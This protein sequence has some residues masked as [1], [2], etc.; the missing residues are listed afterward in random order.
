MRRH[1]NNLN[2]GVILFLG[3]SEI[4]TL[5][6]NHQI[7]LANRTLLLKE[8]VLLTYQNP[9]SSIK[10]TKLSAFS[11]SKNPPISLDKLINHEC[12]A[13]L[14]QVSTRSLRR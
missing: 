9:L 5:N 7:S 6:S 3:E 11:R 1:H 14:I 10:D 4:I 13:V 2:E 12:K 8:S